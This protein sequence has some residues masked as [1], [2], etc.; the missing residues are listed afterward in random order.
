[1]RIDGTLHHIHRAGRSG[2]PAFLDDHAFMAWG[3]LELYAADL[4]PIWL[5]EAISLVDII[6]T[7]FMDF[8]N[9][10]FF[11]SSLSGEKVGEGGPHPVKEVY[12]GAVP[13]GNSIAL[14][15]LILL[16]N[17]TGRQE[18]RI[19]AERTVTALSGAVFRAPD[20]HTQFLNAIDLMLGPSSEVVL[21]GSTDEIEPFLSEM[22]GSFLPHK[23]VVHASGNSRI[24]EL[25]PLAHG[26]TASGGPL[27][28]VCIGRT[29]FPPTSHPVEMV[30][31]LSKN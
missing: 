23:V 17:I 13:S 12:D 30:R 26:R 3:L 4:R 19:A 29:C 10:G 7:E 22:G 31:L 16:Y 11:Q 25:S 21:T 8:Q 2:G 24:S 28:Y 5:E 15:D 14:L 1:M 9:G 27:A 6:L 20:D 18:Y